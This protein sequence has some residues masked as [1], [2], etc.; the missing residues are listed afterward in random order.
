MNNI[1]RK[2]CQG[3]LKKLRKSVTR[4]SRRIEHTRQGKPRRPDQPEPAATWHGVAVPRGRPILQIGLGHSP[5]FWHGV[6]VP[7]GTTVPPPF[8]D[9]T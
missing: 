4:K 1:S 5:V 7:R 6:A 8:R 3:G 9:A 2:E